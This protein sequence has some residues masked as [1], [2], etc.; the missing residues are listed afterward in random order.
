MA[1]MLVKK[2]DLSVQYLVFNM[3]K[4]LDTIPWHKQPL[5]W[6]II[7]I[8]LSAVFMGVIIMYLAVTTD[9]GL[10]V[11]DYYKKGMTINRVLEKE[12]MARRMALSASVDIDANSGFITVVF[13]KGGLNDYPSQLKLALKH[14][15]KQ[16]LDLYLILQKGIKNNYVGSIANGVQQGIWHIELSNVSEDS[17][18]SWR[19]ARRVRLEEFTRVFVAYE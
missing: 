19:L 8:P 6:M 4:Q 13:D 9:D 17:V 16:Q 1:C 3:S 5:V 2:R 14:A 12:H 15:A 18:A 7:S 10:V 11:D